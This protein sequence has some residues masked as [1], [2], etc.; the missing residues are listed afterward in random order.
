MIDDIHIALIDD[1]L[2]VLDFASLISRME[3]GEGHVLHGGR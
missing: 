2:A 1:D 3:Q